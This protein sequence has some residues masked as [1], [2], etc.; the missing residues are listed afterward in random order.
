MNFLNPLF[1]FGLAAAAVPILIHLFT[2]KRPREMK[3]PSLEFLAEVNRS[4]I[5]R[6][7]LKQW[8]LLLLRTLAIVAL[9]LAMS[10]PAL[11]GTSGLG[12]GA[13][14]TVVALVDQS[15]SMG[16]VA[17]GGTLILSGLLRTQAPLVR[18][19]YANR[20]QAVV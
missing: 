6:L 5:R 18:E 13:S 8:L 2:R 15:G 17:S 1:L 7:R 9:A 16:A 10:R 20:G 4:E 3:F 12:R 14:T 19:A 11:K